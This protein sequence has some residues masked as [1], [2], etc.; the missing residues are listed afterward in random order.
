[1]NNKVNNL[2]ERYLRVIYNDE[3]SSFRELLERDEST[4]IHNRNIQIFN[5]TI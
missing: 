4:S 3:R 5:I 1:M 2:H